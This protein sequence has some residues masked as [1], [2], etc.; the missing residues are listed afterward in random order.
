MYKEIK[1]ILEKAKEDKVDIG[2][3]YD[4]L[5]RTDERRKAFSFLQKNQ[6]AILKL[7]NAGREEELKILC[8][9]GLAGVDVW[10]YIDALY[11]SGVIER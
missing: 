11:S 3:A 6:V 10:K 2:V 1:E 7:Y 4:K 5:L 9:M 8:N